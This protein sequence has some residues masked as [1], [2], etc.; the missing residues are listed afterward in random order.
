MKSGSKSKIN[1]SSGVSSLTNTK[2]EIDASN[3]NGK[4]VTKIG[5]TV[6]VTKKK[7]TKRDG[8]IKSINTRNSSKRAV[9][10][11]NSIKIR[12]KLSVTDVK[13]EPEV[14]ES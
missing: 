5:T 9:K 7:K 12:R 14:S 10:M 1:G 2:K 8:T 4:N 6:T 11:Y 3:G 13:E